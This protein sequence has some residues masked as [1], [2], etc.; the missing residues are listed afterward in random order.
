[1]IYKR[2]ESSKRYGT[3]LKAHTKDQT[4]FFANV[5]KMGFVSTHASS[6]AQLFCPEIIPKDSFQVHSQN[7]CGK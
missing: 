5:Y 6:H 1:V 3:D 4:S 7:N 2:K